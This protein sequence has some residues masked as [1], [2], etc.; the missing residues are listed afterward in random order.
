M[1]T[2]HRHLPVV[3]PGQEKHV[4]ER[5]AVLVLALVAVALYAFSY[6]QPWWHLWFFAPQYPK[7]L[8]L[9]IHLNKLGADVREVD[10]LNHYIGMASLT[11]AAELERRFAAW[12]V[13]LV[14][15]V[16]MLAA[17]VPGKRLSLG[18]VVPGILF[19]IGFLADSLYWLYTFG[20]H[21]D[22]KAPI[23]IPVFTPQMFGWGHIGQFSTYARPD[24]GFWFAV[25]GL[26]LLASAAVLR[27][28]V[29][30]TCSHAESCGNVCPTGFVVPPSDSK[31][32]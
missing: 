26:V 30:A 16:A 7:G 12:G 19:P 20:H 29:C 23:H 8:Q 32:A 4:F 1:N 18:V 11:H 27:R 21:L 15:A 31:V 28:R 17:I 6:T 5:R 24:T 10:M 25:A 3:T 9:T 2:R 22:R 13:G 14:G